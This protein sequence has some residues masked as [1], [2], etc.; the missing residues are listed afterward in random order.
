MPLLRDSRG[1]TLAEVVAAL[2]LGGVLMLG[3][4]LL[5]DQLDDAEARI[6]RESLLVTR[7]ANGERLLR[8]LLRDA[9]AT[10]DTNERFR[11]DERSVDFRGWCATQS[12]WAERC[13]VSLAI[14]GRGDTSA[15][16]AQLST[17]EQLVL[18]TSPRV[19]LVRY[20]DAVGRDP[21]WKS[22]WGSS[23]TLP[24]AIGLVTG[25]DTTVYPVGASR[26]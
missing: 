12:G 13:R 26:E 17:G 1:F 9:E 25:S 4:R 8:Q 16:V 11:G 18:T 6:G 22:R 24:L 7:L 15:L 23:L 2:A 3:G 20:F 19:A 10:L 5:L 21:A 14:D